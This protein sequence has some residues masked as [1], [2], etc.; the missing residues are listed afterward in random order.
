MSAN[1]QIKK[2]VLI[3]ASGNLGSIILH[4]LLKSKAHEVTILTRLSSNATF[5]V[6]VSVIKTSY[7]ESELVKAFGGQDAVVSSVGPTGFQDQ[8]V[9]ID[10]AITAGVKRFIPSEFSANTMSPTVRELVPVFEA[11]KD[12]IDYPREKEN[13][14]LT[15]T[16]LSTG[17]LLDWGL[18]SGFLG[19]DLTNK[20]AV[21]WDGG[22]AAFSATSQ[23]D[24]GQAIVSVLTHPAETTNQF[25]YFAT[26]T[27]THKAI[28]AAL[29]AQTGKKWAVEDVET[30]EEI[31]KGKKM[32][33]EGDFTGIFKLVRASA[34]G[35]VPGI[36]SNYAVAEKLANSILGVP[37]GD[38][39]ETV[40]IVLRPVRS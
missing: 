32:V 11:K 4:E 2:V 39:D 21:L 23:T 34:W 18:A 8:K 36:R 29:E 16:G 17:P 37:H 35:D 28:L 3:G 12:I 25:L 13:T 24:L 1:S 6:D 38:L 20:K 19:F 7:S 30:E 15:W 22:N 40:K 10:A 26:V 27:T 9:F 5:P 31:A 14:G 33:S